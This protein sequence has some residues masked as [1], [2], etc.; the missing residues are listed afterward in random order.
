MKIKIAFCLTFYFIC[1]SSEAQN[2]CSLEELQ[3]KYWQYKERFEKHFIVNDG[4]TGNCL[5]DGIGFDQS[6]ALDNPV[7]CNFSKAGYGLPATN[8]WIAPDGRGSIENRNNPDPASEAGGMFNPSCGGTITWSDSDPNPP[9]FNYLDV[10]SE[11]PTQMGWYWTTLATEYKLMMNS[12]QTQEAQKVLEKIFLGLQAYRRL[13]MQANCLLKQ[14]YENRKLNQPSALLCDEPYITTDGGQPTGTGCQRIILPSCDWTPDFSGYSGWCLRSDA[15]QKLE[16]L[17]HDPTD[18][19]Y[20]IDGVSGGLA[21]A[22]SPPCEQKIPANNDPFCSA[23]NSKEF[24]SQDQIIGLLFGLAF[25]KQMVPLNANIT[26]CGG[27]VFNIRDMVDK[28]SHGLV[29]PILRDNGHLSVPGSR[30]CCAFI[31]PPPPNSNNYPPFKSAINLTNAQGGD[32]RATAKGFDQANDYI[33][34]DK[35]EHKST[36]LQRV[37]YKGTEQFVAWNSKGLANGEKNHALIKFF[38]QLQTIGIDFDDLSCCGVTSFPGIPYPLFY[39]PENIYKNAIKDLHKE[40]YLLANDLLHPGGNGVADAVGKDW[41]LERLCSAPC[42]GPCQKSWD[43]DTRYDDPKIN[44]TYPVARPAFECANTPYW[45]GQ[46]WDGS[47]I[48]NELEGKD[49]IKQDKI[50]NGLEFMALFNMYMLRYEHDKQFYPPGKFQSTASHPSPDSGNGLISGPSFIPINGAE[51]Y[52]LNAGIL[53]MLKWTG[54]ANLSLDLPT[55]APVEVA[56]NYCIKPTVLSVDWDRHVSRPEFFK[57]QPIEIKMVYSNRKEMS[58]KQTIRCFLKV[59]K[60]IRF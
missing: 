35:T 29:E 46:N 55:S 2:A 13:D 36:W 17:L 15:T 39:K 10:N 45:L 20:N 37:A 8:I 25:I 33:S 38:L 50:T 43:Y 5:N 18:P 59:I 21:D 28:I 6:L 16:E 44:P 47:G 56:L 31:V 9:K 11:T 60:P 22:Q 19:L 4:K 53:D 23:L 34:S 57:G 58:A 40:I 42:N 27:E 51:V 14:A 26:V 48:K 41:F 54:T 49:T 30:D 52:D 3:A 7:Q 24:L 32:C 1:F 12:G